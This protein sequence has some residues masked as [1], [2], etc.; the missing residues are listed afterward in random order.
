MLW[1]VPLARNYNPAT[2]ISDVSLCVFTDA[3]AVRTKV[4]LSTIQPRPLTTVL[5]FEFANPC[6]ADL[7]GD[8]SVSTAD[9]LEFLTAFGQFAND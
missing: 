7:N 8:G 6:P 1:I 3:A 9:L 2:N 5:A 4:L